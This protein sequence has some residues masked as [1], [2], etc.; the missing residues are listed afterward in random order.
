M[1]RLEKDPYLASTF[2]TVSILDRAP[3]FHDLRA[4][5][6]AATLEVPRLRW[7]VQPE[8]ERLRDAGVGRRS[9]LRH[10]PA[11]PPHRPAQAGH[12]PRAA[13]PRQPDAA[14][15]LRSHPAAVAV[16]DRRRAPRRQ[17]GAVVEDAPHDHRRRGRRA[18]VV[19]VPRLRTHAGPATAAPTH[20]PTTSP[21]RP[22][23]PRRSARRAACSRAASG[24]RS[25]S[26]GRCASCSPT[27]RRSPTPR[28]PRSTRCAASC[29]S[30]PRP[31][32]PARRCG[33]T[34]RCAA[35]S[36]PRA[37]RSASTKDAA[38]RLG[39]TLNT[40]FLTAAADAAGRY[41]TERGQPVDELRASMA[42]STRTATPGPTP[43]PSPGCSCRPVRCP[44]PS[45]SPGS[46]TSRRRPRRVTR[47]GL[48]R[49]AGDHHG[50]LADVADHAARPP[51]GPDRRLRHLQRPGRADAGLH[52]RRPAARELRRS[53]RCSASPST[54]RCCR[55]TAASTWAS[56][57]TPPPSTNRR[58]WPSCVEDSFKALTRAGR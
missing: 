16:H 58:G 7:R 26:P 48:A 15:P 8:P 51:A 54:S 22:R 31:T 57:S 47:R 34:A 20:Q 28:W 42:V 44:S 19:A 39:G 12:P 4:R 5:M 50:R 18:D 21:R 35:A 25:A 43:S 3:D 36:R 33:P 13:R 32:R 52:R 49:L 56:T 40:A 11:R 23:R 9:R 30:C 6:E 38:K 10:R 46:S 14:R 37:C 27:R 41:H 24:S 1:W 2:G 53:A 55:T 45:A 17:G 29:P